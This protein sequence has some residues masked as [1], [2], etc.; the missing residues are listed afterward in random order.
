MHSFLL[1]LLLPSASALLAPPAGVAPKVAGQA[2]VLETLTAAVVAATESYNGQGKE[3]DGSWCYDKDQRA[4][5]SALRGLSGKKLAWWLDAP[6][7]LRAVVS[8]GTNHEVSII[9]LPGGSQLPAAAFPS[10]SVC[11]AQPL[12]GQLTIRRLRLPEDRRSDAAP[13]ELMTRTIAQGG[14]PLSLLGGC[15]HEWSSN[16]GIASAMLQ[17]V[18]L[19]PTARF[20]DGYWGRRAIGWVRP[21]ADGAH[22]EGELAS[23]EVIDLDDVSD[24]LEVERRRRSARQPQPRDPVESLPQ[25]QRRLREEVG[26]LDEQLGVIAR[27]ALAARLCPP[28]LRQELGVRPVRGLL[29]HG[30]PGCGKTL[31]AR[32]LASALDAREP[33]IVNGPEIMSKYVGQSEENI[34]ALFADAE[35]EYKE[36]GDD[37]DLHIIIFDE[38]D[39]ICKARG[40]QRNDTGVGD[41]VVNQLLSKID[42]VDSL[43]NILVIGMTNRKDMMDD[44]LLRPGRL[45]VQV[46]IALPDEGGRLQILKIHTAKMSEAGY[47]DKGVE[48]PELAEKSK[49]FSGAELEGLV[50]A[51]SSYA[52]SRTTGGGDNL[53]KIDLSQLRVERA[54]FL[55]G[56]D[57]ITPSFGVSSEDLQACVRGGV[58]QGGDACGRLMATARGMIGQ[59][60]ASEA[61]KANTSLLSI[62]LEGPPGT[63]KTAL[64]AQLALD[65]GCAF[66]KLLSPNSMIGASE[67]AKAGMIAKVFDDAHK[68]PLSLVILDDLERLLEYVRIG[69]R[70]SNVV[71]QTLLVCVKKQPKA[72]H[73]LVVVGTS[74][75]AAVLEQLE[76][77]DVFNV[78]LHVPRLTQLEATTVLGQLGVPNVAEVAGV[79]GSLQE[80]VAVKKLLLVVE[81]SLVSGR[82]DPARFAATLQEAGVL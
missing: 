11:F 21:P 38:I 48:L 43:N 16:A 2:S 65:S 52:L 28:S 6:R 62:L 19:P 20:P 9:C 3:R 24:L 61:T 55:R 67:H 10:G 75:S 59:L 82:L 14:E 33:K 50:K 76:L 66:C 41:S 78:A 81:M 13:I 12:V 36:K 58:L 57:E 31:C 79:L 60:V 64:A 44:A 42:G 30:P 72:G 47:L 54:D 73:K 4:V 53:K 8:S 23:G 32:A 39:S 37:S 27:R 5:E 15:V 71:L 69:P 51:A 1:S 56:L 35:V 29:L 7:P 18:M 17:V 80:P 49:N 40:S 25:L 74:S 70:F 22:A 77:L 46:Q 34:R 68:S 63:G 45:E 26:G